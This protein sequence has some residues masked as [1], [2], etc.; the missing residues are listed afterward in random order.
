MKTLAPFKTK[1]QQNLRILKILVSILFIFIISKNSYAQDP[2]LDF[3]DYNEYFYNWGV[4]GTFNGTLPPFNFSLPKPKPAAV[5][6]TITNYT[7]DWGDGSPITTKQYNEF[8]LA[9]TYNAEGEYKLKISFTYNGTTYNYEYTVYHTFPEAKVDYVDGVEGCAP[10]T[11]TFKLIN[12][13]QNPSTTIYKI[14]FGDGSSGIIKTHEELLNEQNAAGEVIFSHTYTKASCPDPFRGDVFPFIRK[15][16]KKTIAGNG[17]AYTGIIIHERGV[18]N[19]SMGDSEN[20]YKKV[21][22]CV[23]KTIF[24]IENQTVYGKDGLTCSTPAHY[25]RVFKVEADGTVIEEAVE[26]VDYEFTNTGGRSSQGDVGIRFLKPG[27]YKAEFEL[28][29]VCDITEQKEEFGIFYVFDNFDSTQVNLQN[30]CAGETVKFTSTEDASLESIK[31]TI[32]KWILPEGATIVDGTTISKD[33][34]LRFNNPGK[35]TVQLQKTSL[36][37]EENLDYEITVHDKPE[38]TL[39]SIPDHCGEYT[40]T[41]GANF[42]SNDFGVAEYNITDYLWTFNNNGIITHSN[43]QYPG[44][45]TFTK[46]GACSVKL[47][48][49]NKCGW[50]QEKEVT[51]TIHPIPAVDFD[52]PDVCQNELMT[53]V[54]EP[55]NM[56]TYK[57]ELDNNTIIKTGKTVTQNYVYVGDNKTKLSVVSKYGCKNSITKNF[58]VIAKPTVDAGT[59]AHICVNNATYKITDAS[60]AEYSSIKWTTDGDGS[61]SNVNALNPT[62]TFGVTDKTKD[63]VILTLTAYGNAPCGQVTST[64]VISLQAAPN[65]TVKSPLANICQGTNISITAANIGASNYNSLKWTANKAGTFIPNNSLTTTFTPAADVFGTVQLTLTAKGL[66]DCAATSKTISLNVVK[67][68]VVNA[69]ADSKICIGEDIHLSGNSDSS[70]NLWEAI[71]ADNDGTLSNP[72]SLNATYTPGTKDIAR[73][74]VTLRLKAMGNAPCEVFDDVTVSL[75]PNPIVNLG[76]NKEVCRN[77]SIFTIPASEIEVKNYASVSWSSSSGGTFINGNQVDAVYNISAADKANESVTLTLSAAPLSPCANTITKSFVLNILP[78]PEFTI[79][80]DFT[81]CE[82]ETINLAGSNATIYCKNFKWTNNKSGDKGTFTDA[83]NIS[84]QYIPDA[85]NPVVGDITFTLT[86]YSTGSCS[87]VSKE[88]KVTYIPKPEANAGDDAEIC[89]STIYQP[90]LHGATKTDAQENVLWEVIGGDG[91]FDNAASINAIYTPG[92]EDKKGRTVTLRLTTKPLTPCANAVSDDMLLTITPEPSA[93]AGNNT[94]ICQGTSYKIVDATADNFQQITWTADNCTFDDEHAINPTYTP[95][96]NINGLQTITMTV[97]GKGSCAPIVRTVKINIT[98]APTV[99]VTPE[100]TICEGG[101]YQ[102]VNTQID[103]ESGYSWDTPA[104]GVFNDKNTLTP[105]FT[106]TETGETNLCLTV[107]GNGTCKEVKACTKLIIK[108]HPT[109]EA[110][111]D[112]EVCAND[113]YTFNVGNNPGEIHA[114]NYDDVKYYSDGDG[115]FINV[116]GLQAQYIPGVNDKINGSVKITI[117]VT[118]NNPCNQ[119]VSDFMILTITPAPVINAGADVRICQESSYKLINATA[120]NTKSVKWLA[121]TKGTFDD[122]TLLNATFTPNA[123]VTGKITLTLTAQGNGSCANA[124]N[125]EVVLDVVPNPTVS[126]AQPEITICKQKTLDMA[127]T[128]TTHSSKI[129]WTTSGTGSFTDDLSL[130]PTYVPSLADYNAGSVILTVTAYGLAP[131][132]DRTATAAVKVNFA[133]QPTVDAGADDI[134]CQAQNT[135]Q[136]KAKSAAYPDGA[137]VNNAKSY[138]WS[139]TGKGNLTGVHTLTPTYT[140]DTDETGVVTF[141]LRAIGNGNC[142]AVESSMKLTIVPSPKPTFT[143]GTN[144]VNSPTQFTATCTDFGHNITNWEWDF[145]DGTTSSEQNPLHAYTTANNFTVTLKVTNNKGCT[146]TVQ[147]NTVANPNPSLDFSKSNIPDKLCQIEP[148][149][150]AGVIALNT[151]ETTFVWTVVPA[152]AGNFSITNKL[153]T[154]FTP[155]SN[156][157]GTAT[158]TLTVQSLYG[159]NSAKASKEIQI[160]KQPT[161]N[162]GVNRRACVNDVIMLTGTSDSDSNIWSTKES[163]ADGVFEDN[164]KSITKYVPGENDIARGFVTFVFTATGNEPCRAEDEVEI[165]IVP[166]PIANAGDDANILPGEDYTLTTASAQYQSA[167][168]WKTSGTGSFTPNN[169][170]EQPTYTPSAEDLANGSVTLTMTVKGETPCMDRTHSDAMILSFTT[171][172]IGS[173]QVVCQNDVV[174]VEAKAQNY[175][176]IHW[177]TSSTN[178]TFADAGSLVTTYT[179]GLLET[180]I[181]TLTLTIVSENGDKVTNHLK[182]NFIAKPKANAGNDMEIC[183]VETYQ[184]LTNGAE[185]FSSDSNNVL[186]TTSGDGYFDNPKGIDAIYF[187]GTTD[188]QGGVI[189]LMLQANPLTPCT[190]PDI[191][192][193]ELT[194]APMPVVFAG[195]DDEICQEAKQYQIKAKSVAY[196]KGAEVKNTKTI[197]WTT[198]GKGNLLNESSLTPTYIFAPNETGIVKFT[199]NGNGLS[200]CDAQQASMQL[201]ILP[202]PKTNFT[203]S[204]NCIGKPTQFADITEST[205]SHIKEWLWDFG[206]GSTSTKQNPIHTYSEIKDFQVTLTTVD[207]KGCTASISKKATVYPLPVV[208]FDLPAKAGVNMPVKFTNKSSNVSVYNW[209]FGDGATGNEIHPEHSYDASGFF[210]VNLKGTSE[211]GCINDNSHKIEIVGAPIAG[212]IRTPDGCGPLTVT[213]TNQSKGKY[214]KFLWDFGNGEQSTKENPDPVVYQAGILADTVYHVTLTVSNVGGQSVYKDEITVKALPVPKFDIL[215]NAYACTPTTREFFNYSEGEPTDYT[216]DFGDGTTYSYDKQ[217]IERPFPHSFTNTGKTKIIYPI[218]LTAR[219][220]C[221]ERS[222]TKNMTVLPNSAVAVIKVDE[223]E[224]CAPF[225]ATFKNLSKGAGDHLKSDWI[226][227]NN[228]VEISDTEGKTVQHTFNEPGEYIVK[229]TVH[230]T[231]AMDATTRKIVVHE[232]PELD[233]DISDDNTCANTKITLT[234]DKTITDKYTNFRWNLGDGTHKKGT[235]ITHEYKE[236][237]VYYVELTAES[238]NFGC[239]KTIHKIIRVNK[240]PKVLF[241][242]STANGC[243]PLE[244]KFYNNTEG[245]SYYKWKFG[246]GNE[247]SAKNPR[248]IFKGGTHKVVL[249]A[250]SKIGCIDSVSKEVHSYKYPDVQFELGSKKGCNAP[251][252]LAIKNTTKNKT[253]NIYTWDFGN[254]KSSSKV[255]PDIVRYDKLGTYR[256]RLQAETPQKCKDTISKLFTIHKAPK[257]AFDFITTSTCEGGIIKLEDKSE[258]TVNTIW[259]LGDGYVTTGR[260]A[261]HV[262]EEYGTYDLFVKVVGEGNCADSILKK[263][264]IK[265]Y[266]KPEADFE[267]ENINTPPDGIVLPETVTPPNNGKVKLTNTTKEFKDKWIEDSNYYYKWDFSDGNQS[268]EKSPVH[269]FEE[270]GKYQVKLVAVSAYNCIDSITRLVK[271]NF[272]GELF[273]PNAFNPENPSHEVGVFLPKGVGLHKYHIEIQDK[274]GNIIWV[275]DKIEKGHPAEGWDGRKNGKLLPQGVYVWKIRAQFKDGSTWKGVKKRGKYFREGTVTLIR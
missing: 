192:E 273:V 77:E 179:P 169:T 26:G 166:N 208:D 197:H 143:I 139:T 60:A 92:T 226:F 258:D 231:C 64:K 275:S 12:F 113:T 193:M 232:I 83:N 33:I 266:P 98:P 31:P 249:I 240:G 62:Y 23:K 148:L 54:G 52:Q 68:P 202:T 189:K 99:S 145:G 242:M 14:I 147:Q 136:I 210:T 102:V 268:E 173:D 123:G 128:T 55:D 206:D 233:F 163:D 87:P 121:S 214:L 236:P 117:E 224:G 200:S 48:A 111:A 101:S 181:T 108:P 256:I 215:P 246:D 1:S 112:G 4:S 159:C 237:N 24:K 3:G 175:K 178:G 161:V 75:I 56:A 187:P 109:I 183:S 73:G 70:T 9:H 126:V 234:A 185:V 217:E 81:A 265:I 138:E 41:P 116:N 104:K 67:K 45:I 216:F 37:G 222:I 251:F 239:E 63:E 110:G 150:I 156:Y 124:A 27:K 20:A 168:E 72:T 191:D 8:P 221:G 229:L 235:T 134:F 15:T 140:P 267:W 184:P 247:S 225:T 172:N 107:Q 131:C 144:C 132:T 11:F 152:E 119:T 142:D 160:V 10:Q 88:V 261:S 238:M 47:K 39:T 194:I 35:Y 133:E 248:H 59:D 93:F 130:T 127:G 51:F 207:N 146:A 264:Y 141:I 18:L 259:R 218:T 69:G 151:D 253:E 78:E 115:F 260:N 195:I 212:F 254:G 244:V 25:W 120:S 114:E 100:A 155:N 65:I 243:E 188:K 149:D 122:P 252:N 223:D 201:N 61:F 58:K 209:D 153:D 205:G 196:P 158:L 46:A 32:Y 74:Y 42:I 164:T 17:E 2:N 165:T 203:I 105:K 44:A 186:W 96:A 71:D 38:V 154:K 103:H 211:A 21:Y 66:Y 19:L 129:K 7:I 157:S 16:G 204:P 28:E 167:I 199:L 171:L 135:Y 86:A 13:S 30:I 174:T 180:G 6:Q 5:A 91:S 272:M 84:T 80:A 228:I 97:Q 53:Y 90:S 270:N 57:W 241:D 269:Q 49:L 137:E 245:G 29:N 36:C 118:Q 82:G 170:T 271:V 125:D 274:Y 255:D 76:G 106:A 40:F 213:F 85:A 263:D 95:N 34:K 257:P 79:P 177:E 220:E 219:N 22:G 89:A 43:A 250:E 94:A 190:N 262:F 162:A 182:V 176:S 230:D 50:S 227:E 198:N